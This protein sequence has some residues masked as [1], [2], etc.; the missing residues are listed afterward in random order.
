MSKL[1]ILKLDGKIEQGFNVTFAVSEEGQSTQVEVRGTLPAVPTSLLQKLQT[2]QYA[3]RS[4]GE[5]RILK[6]PQVTLEGSLEQRKL[7]CNQAAETLADSFNEWLKDRSLVGIR[8]TWCNRVPPAA[9][10]RLVLQLQEQRLASLPWHRWDL[11]D[12]Y[13]QLELGF[14]S[15]EYEVQ[16]N[17]P[18][19]FMRILAILGNSDGIDVQRDRDQ[20]E[21]LPGAKV[22]VLVEPARSQ[23]T[24]TLWQQDWDI[25][26]FAGHSCT[27]AETGLIYLN[28]T[29]SLSLSDLQKTLRQSIRRGL[30]LAIFNSC[31]GLGLAW[32]LQQLHIPQ[33]I[34]MREPIADRVAQAFLQQFLQRFCQ[35]ESFYSAVRQARESLEGL[36]AEFP[37]A[38]WL[39]MIWQNP[40]TPP[41]TWQASETSP[42]KWQRLR[43]RFFQVRW[44]PILPIALS[45][46]L[47]T[48]LVTVAQSRGH[49]QTLELQAFDRML[50]LRP[51]EGVDPELLIIEITEQDILS[52]QRQREPLKR[53]ST[54]AQTRGEEFETSLPD[55]TLQRL[56]TKLIQYQ[57]Q[58]IGLDVYRDFA[59]LPNQTKLKTLLRNT[60]NLITVC[61]AGDYEDQKISSIDPL[62]EIPTSQFQTRVGFSD[63]QL[64][65]DK[66]LR[67]HLLSMFPRLRDP[68]D[69][70]KINQSF[71]IQLAFTYLKRKGIPATYTRRNDQYDD[72][73]LGNR[74]YRVLP[75]EGSYY[76]SAK[77]WGG[78]QIFINYRAND[79]VAT[80]YTLQE[81][82][83]QNIN[84]D[85]IKDKIVLIGI[86]AGGEGADYWKTPISAEPVPGVAIHAHLVSQLI[87]AAMY[88]RPL[89]WVWSTEQAIAWVLFWSMIGGGIGYFGKSNSLRRVLLQ[90]G[91]VIVGLPSIILVVCSS[92]LLVGGWLPFVPA[93]IAALLS[94]F[95]V[96]GYKIARI[97]F[98]SSY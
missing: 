42:T 60:P 46:I 49:L 36:E 28:Q 21:A 47:S 93:T 78:N 54:S 72:V 96:K 19:A 18:H 16:P 63:F 48:S 84:P 58:V 17:S 34:V 40:A 62:P 50:Q 33:M 29:E 13:P 56:L 61:K 83:T 95:T 80:R 5:M 11:L 39:P 4:F 92:I 98:L 7:A 1:L 10:A 70:C 65:D 15:L 75:H 35:G 79:Q 91:L 81:F 68:Q 37:C 69:R 26:F 3:Y 53:I 32:E 90:I 77:G 9:A 30:K 55:Q 27:E 41:L 94:S 8:E 51:S 20:L 6:N 73:R 44:Q 23:L 12:R 89:I 2:W 87:Q 66:V 86:T 71:S 85:Y 59:A 45:S 67:R 14:S 43:S 52:Q 25:L 74:V 76:R 82:L 97:H 64:D 38:S 24:E 88:Q 22:T 57:P 31:D